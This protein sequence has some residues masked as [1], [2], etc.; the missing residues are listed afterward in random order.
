MLNNQRLR[1]KLDRA[2]SNTDWRMMFGDASVTVFPRIESDHHP[3]LL[4]T[5][6]KNI[7]SGKRHFV[8]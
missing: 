1:V 5:K 8:F 4:R 3:L 2:I 6:G 7:F